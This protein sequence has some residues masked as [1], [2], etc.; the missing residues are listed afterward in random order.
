MDGPVKPLEW[1]GRSLDDLRAM[2]AAVRQGLGLAL[3]FA[4]RG[5]MHPSAKS[6]RGAGLSG[7][8]EIVE[9]YAGTAYRAAYVTRVRHVISVLHVFQ[10]KSKRGISTPQLNIELIKSRLRDACRIEE[11]RSHGDG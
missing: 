3:R 9:D 1:M 2:P 7:V 6:M 10:K 8:I 11:G 4:Q 5:G